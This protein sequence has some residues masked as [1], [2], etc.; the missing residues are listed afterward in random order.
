VCT[1]KLRESSSGKGTFG[2]DVEC[3]AGESM[4]EGKLCGEK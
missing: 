4:R 3:R 2:G 1:Q